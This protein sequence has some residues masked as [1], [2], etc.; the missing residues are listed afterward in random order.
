M[1]SYEPAIIKMKRE[2]SEAVRSVGNIEY[3]TVPNIRNL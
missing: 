2:I 3:E 1:F